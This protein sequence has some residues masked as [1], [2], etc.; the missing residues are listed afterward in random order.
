[1]IKKIIIK[2]QATFDEA[3]VELDNLK[4]INV[5]YGSNGTGKST[6]GRVLNDIDSFQNSSIEWKDDIS[7]DILTYN[8]EFCEKN[9]CEQMPGVFTLGKATSE[10][11]K[12]I[13]E[14]KEYLRQTLEAESKY[15]KSLKIQEEQRYDKE[16]SFREAVWNDLLKRYKDRFSKTAIA[17]GTKEKFF[18]KVLD[19][20]YKRTEP[21]LTLEYLTDRAK[22]IFNDDRVCYSEIDEINFIELQSIESNPIWSKKIVGNQDLDIAS[23]IIE[24]GNSDWVHQGLGYIDKSGEICPFC[25]QRTLNKELKDKIC[26]FFDASYKNDIST[27]RKMQDD[28]NKFQNRIVN[29]LNF[30]LENNENQNNSYL[31]IKMLDSYVLEFKLLIEKNQNLILKKLKEPS[32]VIKLES[33]NKCVNRINKILNDYNEKVNKNNQLVDN[34]TEEHNKLVSQIYNFYAVSY[35]SAIG[36]YLTEIDSINRAIDGLTAKIETAI[37]RKKTIEN[38]IQNLE[39]NITSIAPAVNEINRLLRVLGFTNFYIR[40]DPKVS[41]HYHIVRENEELASHTLSEGEKNFI[42]FLYYMQLVKGS[43][44]PDG[45]TR[46][47]ILVIDDPVSSLDSNVLFIIS[48]LLRE[49]FNDIHEGKSSVKQVILLTHNVYFHKE[50]SFLNKDCK[51]KDNIYYWIIRKNQNI[52]KIEFYDKS[53]PVKSSYDLLW[54]EIRCIDGG[55]KENHSLIGLQ[56]SMRRIIENYFKMFGGISCDEIL[57]KFENIDEKRMCKSLLSWINDGSHSFLDDIY[58]ESLDSQIESYY[59]IFKKIFVVMGQDA[60]YEMMMNKRYN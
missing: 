14:K 45:V 38:E 55:I 4:P 51:W 47:R 27:I 30:L 50:V 24:L 44:A 1:M 11:I 28:Y 35:S 16:S 34:V 32:R 43:H 54:D 29:K 49:V 9:Y 53:N 57:N 58:V 13:N 25:Q 42:T 39:K 21:A 5:I 37:T 18:Q 3:G 36:A 41:N 15:E 20:Y 31:D 33:S 56:N 22:M 40:E 8:K 2:N 48:T 17:G 19:A 59:E 23:L 60:H 6:V 46:D 26:S 10:S 52:S 7:L 12:Q